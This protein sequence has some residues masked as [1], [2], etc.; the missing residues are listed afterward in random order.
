MKR[1]PSLTPKRRLD[2]ALALAF[3]NMNRSH[4]ASHGRILWIVYINGL[5][6]Q[7]CCDRFSLI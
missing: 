7:P 2:D 5:G 4:D 6:L 1:R 3:Y